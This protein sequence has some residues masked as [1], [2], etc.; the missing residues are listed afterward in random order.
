MEV[1]ELKL[2]FYPS[3]GRLKKKNGAPPAPRAG[4]GGAVPSQES[5]EGRRSQPG[6]LLEAAA[7]VGS[8]GGQ[9]LHVYEL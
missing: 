8:T 6:G 9:H 1:W 2:Y 3:A 7:R 4:D 5:T